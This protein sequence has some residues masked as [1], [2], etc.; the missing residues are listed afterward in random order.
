M[1]Y[2]L[3]DPNHA[4]TLTCSFKAQK[5]SKDNVKNSPCDYSGFTLNV[6]KR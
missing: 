1:K 5:G 6:M 3:S 4:Y 2:E